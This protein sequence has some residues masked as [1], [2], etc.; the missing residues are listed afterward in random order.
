MCQIK[1]V[2][3]MDR[4]YNLKTIQQTWKL[5]VAL[6]K[7]LQNFILVTTHRNFWCKHYSRTFTLQYRGRIIGRMQLKNYVEQSYIHLCFLNP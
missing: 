5:Y 4:M 7:D 2:Y 3:N 6:K 1:L